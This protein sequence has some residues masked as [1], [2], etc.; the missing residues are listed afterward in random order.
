MQVKILSCEKR[1]NG[2]FIV[3][4][5]N[6]FYID[7][8]GGQSGDRGKIN[9]IDVLNVLENGI[10][11]RSPLENG[12]YDYDIDQ[13]RRVHIAENHSAQHVF[14]AL[15]YKNFKLNTVGFR[16]SE[17]YSTVDLDV[18]DIDDEI[19]KKLEHG[20]NQVILDARTVTIKIF[21]HEEA[22]KVDGIRRGIKS[23][24]TGDVRLV[25]IEDLDL[26]A[27]AGFHVQ[28]TKDIRLFKIL[29]YEKIKGEY[30]RFFYIAGSRA[31]DDYIV[32]HNILREI[33]HLFSCKETETV[34]MISKMINDKKKVD[35]DEKNIS[36]KYAKLL[37][38]QLM[39]E[40]IEINNIK[41]IYYNENK[42]VASFLNRYINLDEFLLITG[43]DS[44]Y[45]IMSNK[46][47]CRELLK[48]LIA[49][50]PQL[51]G[52]GKPERG[53]FKGEIK[54]KEL[55]LVITNIVE[56]LVEEKCKIN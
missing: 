14:S 8:K 46:I 51:K 2:F 56:K 10:I 30:T 37:A 48:L 1:E 35:S 29:Y 31:I 34:N 41:I 40:A 22:M 18:L 6:P 43:T 42:T 13:E 26:S 20:V 11:I 45:S 38:E 53:N 24:V 47:D 44:S 55:L 3:L 27:C 52:G 32:K 28:N 7:G 39:I 54:D 33:C 12:T 4:E 5:E 15:A 17:E 19:I 21:P 16:M 49:E 9:E 50:C 23:K 36:D 25:K